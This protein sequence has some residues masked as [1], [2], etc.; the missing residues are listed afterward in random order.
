MKVVNFVTEENNIL[1]NVDT[2][3]N[4]LGTSRSKIQREIKRN[5][6]TEFMRYKNQFLYTEK[7]L[8]TI[9]EKLLIEKLNNEI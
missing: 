8:F 2:M 4:L 5:G 3:R 1:Y 7:S 9:M 6:I